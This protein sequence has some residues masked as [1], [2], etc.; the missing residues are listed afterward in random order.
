MT[1]KYW[2]AKLGEVELKASTSCVV[3]VCHDMPLFIA[4][5]GLTIVIW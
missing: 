2:H 4:F 3:V 1:P 5:T